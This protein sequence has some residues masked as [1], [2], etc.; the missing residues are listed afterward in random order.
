MTIRREHVFQFLHLLAHAQFFSGTQLA[1]RIMERIIMSLS[2][3]LILSVGM[4][5][6][7]PFVMAASTVKTT[8]PESLEINNKS[9]TMSE[10]DLFQ[11]LPVKQGRLMPDTLDDMVWTLK[12]YQ[13]YAKE[14]NMPLY[15][16]CR[17]KG[18]DKTVTL[19]V[20]VTAK[21]CSAWFS[22]GKYAASCE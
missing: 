7:T 12:D 18:T 1:L 20:P 4:L 2:K 5:L 3:P 16:V 6:F 8:C 11:G 14:M 22:N 10:V 13:D 17:Y 9:Y 19:Q 15:L 21:K